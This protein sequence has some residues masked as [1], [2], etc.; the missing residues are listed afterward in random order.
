MIRLEFDGRLPRADILQKAHALAVKH[1]RTIPAEGSLIIQ[2]E[3][4]L[5]LSLM[6]RDYSGKIDLVY[7]D[8][9]F[10][11]MQD[12]YISDSRANSVSS[13]KSRR[14]Y[15]DKMPPEKFLAFIRERLILIHELLSE[16]GSLYLH[17]DCKTGHYVKIILDEIFGAGNF[18]N[19]IA[20]IKSNPKNFRRRAWGNERDM[21]LFYAKNSGLNI[22]N[23]ITSPLTDSEI[24]RLFPKTD[25][26]GRRYTTIPL[27]APGETRGGVTGQA[28]RNIPVP[29]GRHWRTDPAEFDRLDAQGLIEWSPS[30]NPRIIKYADEHRGMKIQD[31]WTYKDPQ[32]PAYPT[33]KNHDML[34]L[35]IAQSSLPESII[36]DPFAGSGASLLCACELGRKFIG[37]D[38]SEEAVRVMRERLKDCVFVDAGRA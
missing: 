15:A 8:P 9:P 23:D 10:N 34:R 11:T 29:E 6:L 20:R 2:S 5:A 21:I 14:A 1:G 38:Q 32:S 36:L 18:L 27:H 17:I 31:V 30:G 24:T 3:N 12:F 4:F 25:A 7:A 16:R 35:I 37:I 33:E 19:D 28:W 26:D 22:W 13:V